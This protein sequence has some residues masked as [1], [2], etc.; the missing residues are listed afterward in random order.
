MELFDSHAHLE[1]EKFEQDRTQLIQQIK[2]AGI[3]RL[4]SAGYSL[5]SSQKAKELAEKYDFIYTASGIS[6]NNIPQTEEELWIMLEGIKQLAKQKDKVVAIGEIGL[7]YHW[8]Q[9]N[10]EMQQLSFI[11]QIELANELKLPI[12]IHTREAVMDTIAILKKK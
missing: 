2:E 1:D 12:V 6:P 5:E 7:D 9:D 10:K 11:Q 3:T 4:I 8:N